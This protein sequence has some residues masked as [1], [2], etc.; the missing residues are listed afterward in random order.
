MSDLANRLK[1]LSKDKRSNL[2]NQLRQ[3]VESEPKQKVILQKRE[4]GSF[5]Q[6]SSQQEQLW[7][8]DQMATDG[9][10]RNNVALLF[11]FRNRLDKNVMRLVIQELVSR[12]ESLRTVF[13]NE[14]GT[15]MQLIRSE[16]EWEFPEH[17]L[18]MLDDAVREERYKQ[19]AVE[20]SARPFSFEIGPLF[21]T[22]LLKLREDDY[23]LLWVAHH[24]LW[25]PGSTAVFIR[26]LMDLYGA[27]AAGSPSP[28]PEL[29][30]QYA[31]YA[32][33]QRDYLQGETLKKLKTFWKNK[34]SGMEVTELPA[35]FPRPAQMTFDGKR[36]YHQVEAEV[37]QAIKEL[38]KKK[39]TTLYM[40]LM[41]AFKVL[42]KHYTGSEDIVVGTPS[43]NRSTRELEA[44]IGFFVNMLVMRTD[45]SGDP[46]FLEVLERVRE[47]ALGVFTHQDLPF[48]KVVET[49]NM[50]RDPS[51][52]PLFQIEFTVQAMGGEVASSLSG[53]NMEHQLVHD[54]G[55]RFD[56]SMIV[57]ESREGLTLIC[58]YN[59]SLYSQQSIERFLTSYAQVLK[60]VAQCPELPISRVSALS[61]QDFRLLTE[62]WSGERE[63][64]IPATTLHELIER[65]AVDRAEQQAVI[66]EGS[67]LS[68]G[69]LN[70]RANR[71]AH[72][73][74]EKNVCAEDRVGVFL[75]RSQDMIVAILAV[76]KA[77]GAYVP[78]DPSYPKDRVRFILDDSQAV[79]LITESGLI[80][81]LEP[82]ELATIRLD[83]TA[84]LAEQPETDPVSDVLPE[85]LAYVI[86]TSGST[87]TPK[88]VMVEHRSAVN[89]T[90]Q[91][92]EEFEI[93]DADRILQFASLSFDV[94]VF[95][96]FTALIA[97]IPL[98]VASALDRRSPENL[99]VLMQGTNVTVA[100]LPPALLPLLDEAALPHLRLVSVGGEMVPGDLV[101]VWATEVRRFINGYGPSEATVAVILNDCKG[102]WK[103][104]P[105]IGRPMANHRAYVVDAHLQPVPIGTPGELCLS[106]AG[107]ARGYLNHPDLT[108]QSFVANPFST[109]PQYTRLYKTGDLA[110]WMPDGK[111]EILGRVDR[112]IKIRGFRV[113]LGEIETVLSEH[114]DVK[115][116]VIE[117]H[118]DQERGRRLIAYVVLNS[119]AV[120]DIK[121]LREFVGSQLPSYM[122]PSVVLEIDQVPLTNNGKVDRKQ[123]PVP[124][125][126]LIIISD[127]YME[128]TN[129][130]EQQIADQIFAQMLGVDRVG[131]KDNFFDLGGNSLQAIQVVSRVRTMFQVEL[132]LVD[133]IQSATVANLANL[134]LNSKENQEAERFRLLDSLDELES[135]SEEE[136]AA[137]LQ[138]IEEANA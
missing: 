34:L 109:D 5:V 59:T 55:S 95:E 24:I 133:F 107:L 19:I 17:D 48:E 7:F 21:R 83:Q 70:R 62:T 98:V 128:P 51:R 118:D 92:I 20:E 126:S 104:T 6:T 125:E 52:H 120:L 81:S 53:F 56:I 15:A 42:L 110:R 26:E 39:G 113:E 135:M 14:N 76:L 137:Y 86:Y 106:G 30:L 37:L 35:D 100:E 65:Q 94:S 57:H 97:G 121:S 63:A 25:D 11:R 108:E 44:M 130:T 12:H 78:I 73:L 138:Q 4:Y 41:A 40:T 66:F 122:V 123:L 89:F 117:P 50:P 127:D 129:E 23:V 116:A 13:A 114:P 79:C 46:N 80:S 31:D 119:G 22:S 47:T 54:G 45:L 84:V 68:Y 3:S 111:L 49:V 28:L 112:Q 36:I 32:L 8:I 85:H 101:G 27:F 136:A 87:G 131:L 88:G 72:L 64:E 99:T 18:S 91:T 9:K 58:E 82:V 75:E 10:A 105:P 1:R 124:D 103:S 69:E 132:S 102:E 33:W 16:V 115:Q 67:T 134:V 43:E 60:T 38:D 93:T 71:L 90:L 29:T 96:V 77:G 61:E 74:L 2:L